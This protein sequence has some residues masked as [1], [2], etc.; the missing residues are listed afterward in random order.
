MGGIKAKA[1]AQQSALK[2]TIN[3]LSERI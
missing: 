2:S 1:I 3:A